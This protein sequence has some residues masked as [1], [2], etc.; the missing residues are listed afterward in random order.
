[1]F[2][3]WVAGFGTGTWMVLSNNYAPVYPLKFMGTTFPCY[4]ALAMLVLNIVVASVLS[5]VFNAVVPD[6]AHDMT[7]AADYA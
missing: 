2:L 3:G 5:L 4:I 7:R 6:K 1:L